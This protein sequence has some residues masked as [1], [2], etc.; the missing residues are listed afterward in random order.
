M[1]ISN[2][3][4]MEGYRLACYRSSKR[5]LSFMKNPAVPFD[6]NEENENEIIAVAIALRLQKL[7]PS[8]FI[9]S[10]KTKRKINSYFKKLIIPVSLWNLFSKEIKKY[11]AIDEFLDVSILNFLIFRL[12]GIHFDIQSINS[13][14]VTFTIDEYYSI[15]FSIKRYNKGFLLNERFLGTKAALSIYIMWKIDELVKLAYKNNPV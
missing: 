9:F 3:C 11:E 10:K 1:K 13:T 6:F 5:I 7:E 4:Y 2:S 14:I 15:T 8:V 12:I